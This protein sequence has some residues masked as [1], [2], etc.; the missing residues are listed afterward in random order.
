M[1]ESPVP[2]FT[3]AELIQEQRMPA[4]VMAISPFWLEPQVGVIPE[5]CGVTAGYP[6]AVIEKGAVLV[7]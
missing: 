1:Q 5:P 4:L 3:Q 6:A 7:E 2:E